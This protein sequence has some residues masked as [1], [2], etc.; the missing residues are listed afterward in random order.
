M[1]NRNKKHKTREFISVIRSPLVN[2][3]GSE[4][5]FSNYSPWSYNAVSNTKLQMAVIFTS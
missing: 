4:T 1:R 3:L 2:L 5:M